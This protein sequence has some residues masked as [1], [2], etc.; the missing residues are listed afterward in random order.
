M[1]I[2]SNTSCTTVILVERL[3]T[4]V[5]V[6][7]WLEAINCAQ[8]FCPVSYSAIP[9]TFGLI[10]D[11]LKTEEAT[12]QIVNTKDSLMTKLHAQ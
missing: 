9:E 2:L 7:A 8:K 6:L 5:L 10:P 4:A 11:T 12:L 3:V 1:L